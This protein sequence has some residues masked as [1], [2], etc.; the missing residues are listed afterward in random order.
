MN[1]QDLLIMDIK[2]IAH[3]TQLEILST[4]L[5]CFRGPRITTIERSDEET[6]RYQCEP[7][8]FPI[9]MTA[10]HINFVD[11][12]D[13]SMFH[14]MRIDPPRKGD[15]ND[16][17]LITGALRICKFSGNINNLTWEQTLKE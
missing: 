1:G 8:Y 16:E 15:T 13:D 10:Y 11:R 4:D 14:R 2:W 3:R 12:L 9:P 17:F 6:I 5:L 7:W